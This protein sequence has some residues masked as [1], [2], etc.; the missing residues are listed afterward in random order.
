M[1]SFLLVFSSSHDGIAVK[2]QL[3]NRFNFYVIPTPRGVTSG[4]GISIRM[5][6]IYLPDI[7][8]V[9]REAELGSDRVQIYRIM[10]NGDNKTYE[11]M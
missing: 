9:L 10:Q 5:S 2:M 3:R 1:E 8:E 11:I 6:M 7:T 4:C